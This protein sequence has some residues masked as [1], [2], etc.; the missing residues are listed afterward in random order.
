MSVLR[1][2]I[3]TTCDGLILIQVHYLDK[4]LDKFF[5]SNNSIVQTTIDKSIYF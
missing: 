2:K 5:K 1:I 3:Y 4:I